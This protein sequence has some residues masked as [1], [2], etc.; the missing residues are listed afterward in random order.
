MRRSGDV[1]ACLGGAEAGSARSEGGASSD[2]EVEYELCGSETGSEVDEVATPRQKAVAGIRRRK[3]MNRSVASKLKDQVRVLGGVLMACSFA[4]ASVAAE[5]VGE[6]IAD[7]FSIFVSSQELMKKVPRE[8]DCLELFAGRGRVSEAFAKK[9]RGAL[10]PRDIKFGHDFRNPAVQREVIED[11]YKFKPGLVWLAPPCT[12]WG[13][14][15]RLNY[16]GQELRRLRRKEMVLVDFCDEV[17]QLQTSLG[18][19]FVLE[20]P[21]GSDMRRVQKLQDWISQS[22]AHLAKVDLCSYQ[23]R[24]TDEKFPLLKPIS[25][26]CSHEK[27]A[28]KISRQC[29]K[30][31]EHMPIQGQNTAHSGIYTTAFANAIVRAYDEAE[32]PRT[33]YP[34]MTVGG[35]EGS[36]A[37]T[38]SPAPH[39]DDDGQ[40]S[41]EPYGAAAISFKGKENPVIAATL[42]RVHQNLRHPPNRELVRHLK[43]GGAPKAVLQAA[44]QLVCRTCERST[45]ARPHKISNP[46]VALDFN[47]VV[48]ADILWIDTADAKNKPALN[49][50]DL[51]STYQVVIPLPGIKSEDVSQAFASG[52]IQWAGVPKQL[53]VDLDSAFKDRFLTLMDEKC[54]IIRAAAGQ[55]HWQNGVCERHG[56]A[57]KAIWAKFVEESLVLEEEII[58]ACAAVSDA[59]NQLRNKSG[60]SPRQW[61]F[62]SNGRQV[63]DLFDGTEDVAAVPLDIRLSVCSRPG[64]SNGGPCCIFPMSNQ[65]CPRQSRF[66]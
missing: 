40:A 55:A 31:H 34:T 61:V 1:A 32:R 65:R 58:E 57:W 18:G 6:P 20:N 44:E 22:R 45:K 66:A 5:T 16:S 36:R 64:T 62:G 50:V 53:L 27:F 29:S 14:F 30:D 59:K 15:S 4:M 51:A 24:S 21:R 23:M 43:I 28:G 9:G 41:P 17:L 60:F 19:Q 2:G 25:L 42:K 3:R 37:R 46:A 39:D 52:W 11:I 56:G 48:A 12:L 33:T 63:G 38:R 8:V 35:G 49:V 13:N 47:E 26:L 7:V 10:Q 54:I